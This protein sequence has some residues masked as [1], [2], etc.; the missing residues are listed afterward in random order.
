MV[1]IAS[2]LKH[3][4]MTRDK[5]NVYITEM[6]NIPTLLQTSI[7]S[8]AHALALAPLV[9]LVA[10]TLAPLAALAALAALVGLSALTVDA[11]PPLRGRSIAWFC[12]SRLRTRSANG[13]C[14][15]TRTGWRSRGSRGGRSGA[16]SLLVPFAPFAPRCQLSLAA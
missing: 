10:L 4:G 14:S 3:V 11:L 15:R 12:S 2:R 9:A 5:S 1:Y 13:P 6:G 8:H 16:D 7:Q